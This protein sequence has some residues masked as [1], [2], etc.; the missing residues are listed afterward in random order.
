MICN[1]C[2]ARVARRKSNAFSPKSDLP[3]RHPKLQRKSYTSSSTTS[4]QAPSPNRTTTAPRQG[5]TA[6]RTSPAATSTSAAQPFST[7]LTHSPEGAGISSTP[8]DPIPPG[9]HDTSKPATVTRLIQSSVP[10]GTPLRG[11]NYLKG[12]SDPLAKEDEAYPAWLWDLLRDTSATG[13]AGDEGTEAGDQFA[14][15]KKQ[16]RIA[17]KEQRKKALLN[18]ESMAPKVALHEQTIDLPSGDADGTMEGALAAIEA[19]G[20]L[21]RAMRAKRRSGIKEHNFLRAMR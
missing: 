3:I 2:L 5:T 14:K 18:P 16:R 4:F 21:T 17:A 10:A 15:S 9:Q 6:S 13:E 19:R 1:R 8:S 7:P 11:L 12:K 20:E